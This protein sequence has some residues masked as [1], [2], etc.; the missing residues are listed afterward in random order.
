MP[1]R[2]WESAWNMSTI[3]ETCIP[4]QYMSTGNQLLFLKNGLI[5][6]TL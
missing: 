3:I 5:L 4:Q 6:K 2:I 1:E